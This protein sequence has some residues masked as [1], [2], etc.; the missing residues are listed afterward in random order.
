M[1]SWHLRVTILIDLLNVL[2]FA[3]VDYYRNFPHYLGSGVSN[4]TKGIV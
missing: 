3:I 4:S 2:L 1:A